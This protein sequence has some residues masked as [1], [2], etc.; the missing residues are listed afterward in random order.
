MNH[1]HCDRETAS[2]G[3]DF[4]CTKCGARCCAIC[5]RVLASA[6]YCGR[7]AESI[8]GVVNE[9]TEIEPRNGPVS[10]TA[11]LV[12]VETNLRT[13][14]ESVQWIVLVA[15]DQPALHAH[16][17][18]AFSRDQKVEI[19]LDRRKDDRRNPAWLEDRLR[20]Q[21]AAVLRRAQV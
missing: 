17:T 14:T 2:D 12:E 3:R 19:V 4:A 5:A 9:P 21:G 11:C 1:C 18:R 10:T 20:A 16:L 6:T 7:C 15:R 13:R 8:L